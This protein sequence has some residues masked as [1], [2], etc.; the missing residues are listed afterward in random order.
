GGGV[1]VSSTTLTMDGVTISTNT[2]EVGAGAYVDYGDTTIAGSTISGNDGGE[3]GLGGGLY[4]IDAMATIT[5]AQITGNTGGDGGGIFAT[6]GELAISGGSLADNDAAL[7][8]GGL[9]QADG[10]VA[11]DG[12]T[13][14]GNTAA[15]WGGGLYA[16]LADLT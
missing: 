13:V 14:S 8:G 4:L 2:G 16:K 11:F 1:A 5:G 6:N 10:A 3:T 7:A 9:Y 15:Y 12:V